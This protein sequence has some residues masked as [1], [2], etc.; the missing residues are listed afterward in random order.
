MVS[1]GG[2]PSICLASVTQ[3]D[4]S[5]PF[6]IFGWGMGSFALK[7]SKAPWSATAPK[8]RE[9]SES[10]IALTVRPYKDHSAKSQCS[11]SGTLR[12]KYTC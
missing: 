9:A 8:S 6:K 2:S 7:R 4:G 1:R 11:D 10:P 5:Q 3:L 12:I